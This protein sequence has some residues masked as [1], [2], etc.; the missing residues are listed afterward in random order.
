M[1]GIQSILEFVSRGLDSSGHKCERTRILEEDRVD[2][3]VFKRV[4]LINCVDE[5]SSTIHRLSLFYQSIHDLCR[6]TLLE[7][8]LP[9][10][11]FWI[12]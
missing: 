6:R 11:L 8:I 2:F 7:K 10:Y 5:R 4:F 1:L 3:E 12:N 9:H